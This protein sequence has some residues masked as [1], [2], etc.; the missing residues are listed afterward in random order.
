MLRTIENALYA[1]LNRR[2]VDRC[3]HSYF[4][5]KP[6]QTNAD[7]HT[8]AMNVQPVEQCSKC[9][10]RRIKPVW[11]NNTSSTNDTISLSG[12]TSTDSRTYVLED[13]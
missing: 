4:E 1:L 10:H 13:D 9:G 7:G 2:R 5:L 8:T 12:T 6:L 3:Q 11:T